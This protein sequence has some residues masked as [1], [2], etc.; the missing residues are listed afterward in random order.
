[1]S[2]PESNA[3]VTRVRPLATADLPEAD[4]IMRLAFG[5]FLKLPD[6]AAFLGDGDFVHTRF[7]ADPS[8]AFA[9]EV[10][11]E[12]AGSSF[13]TRW[14]AVGFFGPLTVHPDLWDRK[15]AQALLEPTLACFDTWG[16]THAGLFTFPHS[17]KHIA[18]YQKFGFWPGHLNPVMWKRVRR[19][20]ADARPPLRY[21]A[22]TEDERASALREAASLTGAIHGGLDLGREIRAVAAGNLG[23]TLFV[24][25]DSGLAAFA[26]CHAGARTEAGSGA[27]YVKFGAARPGPHAA[28][29]FEALLSACEVYAAERGLLRFVAGVSTA[30]REAYR[31]M[32]ARGFR[33]EIAGLTMIRGDDPGYRRPGVFVIDD[34]R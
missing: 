5:T 7:A 16:T 21:S 6:P 20:P 12:L 14:G 34:W 3:H 25:R 8:A 30:R 13:A 23:D 18:L 10:D 24:Q 11:G 1:M 29:D 28:V 32:L 2:T 15:I 19:A 22:M 4:R 9:A 17:P 31:A 33:I 27:L 26:V